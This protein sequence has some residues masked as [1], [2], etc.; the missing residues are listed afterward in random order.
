MILQDVRALR[1]FLSSGVEHSL[2]KLKG[3]MT[4]DLIVPYDD[5]GLIVRTLRINTS[6]KSLF[7]DP[8][9]IF[10]V[11]TYLDAS[12]LAARDRERMASFR[13]SRDPIVSAEDSRHILAWIQGNAEETDPRRRLLVAQDPGHDPAT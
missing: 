3:D 2:T 7:S 10:S 1:N 9:P 13:L 6:V 12:M 11:R 4:Y 8:M 5:G